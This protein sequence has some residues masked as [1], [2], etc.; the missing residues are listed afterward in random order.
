MPYKNN[1]PTLLTMFTK[2]ILMCRN[3]SNKDTPSYQLPNVLRYASTS[4]APVTKIP[5]G[6]VKNI[7]SNN[8]W[9]YFRKEKIAH[10]ASFTSN[11]NVKMKLGLVMIKKE[12]L[13]V[14][15]VKRNK[16]E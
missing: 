2:M 5:T 3:I 15:E 9:V 8:S 11:R 14:V 13:F 1:G 16:H 12:L 10:F 4:L 7:Q 6:E